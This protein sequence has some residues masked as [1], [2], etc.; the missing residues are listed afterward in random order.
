[1]WTKNAFKCFVHKKNYNFKNFVSS[2]PT[3]K[4]SVYCWS[5]F[6]LSFRSPVQTRNFIH[7]KGRIHQSFGAQ[8]TFLDKKGEIHFHLQ[9]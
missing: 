9:N 1:M 5:V 3:F 4:P 8:F 2:L 7:I 6:W